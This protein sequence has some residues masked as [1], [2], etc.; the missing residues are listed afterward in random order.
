MTRRI[1]IAVFEVPGLG[2]ASSSAYA[3]FR[4]MRADG[5]DVHLVN[6]VD[7]CDLPYIQYTFG[8]ACGNPGGLGNVQT[9]IVDD[10]GHRRHEG[11]A[12]LVAAIG[13]DVILG[14]G[15]I[16]AALVKLAAPTVGVV[17]YA[18]GSQQAGIWL[19]R[20]RVPD[21]LALLDRCVTTVQA[22]AVVP[23]RE[24]RA[25]GSADLIVACSEMIRALL[26]YF[27]PYPQ[28]CK[29]FPDVIPQA[30]WI[31]EAAATDGGPG[32][33]FS[34]REID[35]LFVASSWRR[36]E[37]N[38]ATV[39]R[40]ASRL[41][42]LRIGIVGEVAAGI[43]GAACHGFLPDAQRV[44][45][46]MADAK[47]VVCPSVF[48]ASPG[49]LFQASAMGC[50]I[51]ASKNCGNW[52]ICHDELLVDP[53]SEDG[54]VAA[55]ARAVQAKR[56]DNMDALLGKRGYARLLEILDVL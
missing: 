30:E 16:A 11:L 15:D 50:N 35:L 9:C 7:A 8:P 55:A 44:L 25:V 54:F 26:E 19:T 31:A 4:K 53:V 5:V 32:K 43:P 38:L 21:G 12:C 56:C 17:F 46:L 34:E 47:A 40:I 3:L 42:N 52:A 18:A 6:L 37:K 49:I 20:G 36:A 2:G 10:T 33:P 48:D 24:S 14:Y 29:V 1:L 27:F 45:G 41:S 39:E 13:P 23:G 28:S 22:P 51:V